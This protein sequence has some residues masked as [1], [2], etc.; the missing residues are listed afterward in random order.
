[1]A[2]PR[3]GGGNLVTQGHDAGHL[4]FPILW[5]KVRGL[6]FS[7]RILLHMHVFMCASMCEFRGQNFVGGGG[8]GR[9]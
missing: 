6:I 1:M 9:M 5:T 8:G 4:S 2:T 3:S 7:I